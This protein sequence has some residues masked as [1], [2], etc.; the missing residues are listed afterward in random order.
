MTDSSNRV[1]CSVLHTLSQP[2]YR[3][4]DMERKSRLARGEG[5]RQE[6]EEEEEEGEGE[7]FIS[8]SHAVEAVDSGLMFKAVAFLSLLFL[9]ILVS[10]VIFK[11]GVAGVG[12][13]G[14]VFKVQ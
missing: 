2:I 14:G 11:Q 13:G 8:G 9:Y 5:D 6:E 3:L 4:G 10:R 7:S 1:P 12:G